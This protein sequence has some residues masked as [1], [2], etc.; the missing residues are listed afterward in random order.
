MKTLIILLIFFVLSLKIL[1][2][3]GAEVLISNNTEISTNRQIEVK[4]YPVSMVFNGNRDYNLR[5]KH[6][7]LSP[8]W[9]YF[10]NTGV[11]FEP[12]GSIKNTFFM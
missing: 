7:N 3:Q 5:A 11:S 8:E 6:Q 2:A 1:F 10:Y 4:I 9:N 12:Q